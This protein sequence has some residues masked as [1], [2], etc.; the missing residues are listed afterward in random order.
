MGSSRRQCFLHLLLMRRREDDNNDKD[1]D[2][3]DDKDE[4]DN[5]EDDAQ[6]NQ[7]QCFHIVDLLLNL[8]LLRR[9]DLLQENPPHTTSSQAVQK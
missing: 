1:E 4:D 3:N 8:L 7:W 2:D 9:V 5:D 6:G